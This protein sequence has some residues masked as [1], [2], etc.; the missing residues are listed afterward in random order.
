MSKQT[1]SELL[2]LKKKR[3]KKIELIDVK[4]TAAEKRPPIGFN[5]KNRVV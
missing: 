4:I 5:Y 1:K 3:E 2:E